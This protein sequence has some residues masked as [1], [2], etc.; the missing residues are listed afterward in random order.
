MVELNN[1]K[2]ILDLLV[3][4][5]EGL[6]FMGRNW[7]QQLKFNWKEIKFIRCDEQNVKVKVILDKYKK[8]FELGIGK[9]KDMRGKFI[10]QDGVSL[11]FC[12]VCEVVYLFRLCVEEE[13]DRL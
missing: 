6:I 1:Q 10:L 7:L 4:N 3:V 11:K 5:N 2:E 12:K 13:F 8:V 9:F